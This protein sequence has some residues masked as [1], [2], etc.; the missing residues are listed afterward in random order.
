MEYEKVS[1]V[2]PT[3]NRGYIIKESISSVLNQT[4]SDFELIIVDD[5]STDDT[6]DI[7]N[8]IDDKRIK[9]IKLEQNSG[10]SNA[11]NIGIEHS[12]YNYIA[13]QDSDDKWL[14][15]KLEKQVKLLKQSSSNVGFVY[16]AIK[17]DFDNGYYLIIPDEK[18]KVE[19]KVKNIYAQMLYDNLI[20]APTLLIKKECFDKVGKFDVS[21][22]SLEDYDF[23]LRLTKEYEAEYIDEVLLDC[24]YSENG[25]SANSYA[26][27]IASCNLVAIYKKDLIANDALN[28]RMETIINGA[29]KLNILDK[30]VPILEKIMKL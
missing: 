8:S 16:H 23:A 15:T 17:Y 13:F 3:Y 26:Y 29:Q 27:L 14:P 20:G 21:W 4:Y 30:I 19:K 10:V 24:T 1:I 6:E 2:L 12:S 5:G 9:Y 11:R 28:H 25:I 18:I 7:I 22:R